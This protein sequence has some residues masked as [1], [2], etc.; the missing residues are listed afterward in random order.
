M[1][2]YVIHLFQIKCIFEIILNVHFYYLS[3]K[4]SETKNST[5][6]KFEFNLQTIISYVRKLDILFYFNTFFRTFSVPFSKHLVL[7]T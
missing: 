4:Q 3:K 2:V 1:D 6:S 7:D 5:N